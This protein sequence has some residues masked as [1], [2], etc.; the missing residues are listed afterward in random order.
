MIQNTCKILKMGSFKTLSK[1]SFKPNPEILHLKSVMVVPKNFYNE[2]QAL[3]FSTKFIQ[4]KAPE[5]GVLKRQKML[6]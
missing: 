5:S 4:Q 2:G 6:I 3:K 1:L